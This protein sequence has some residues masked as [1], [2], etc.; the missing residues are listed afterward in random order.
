MADKLG[1]NP[2]KI[3][4]ALRNGEW[5]G[6]IDVSGFEKIKDF[7]EAQNRGDDVYMATL[8]K[9]R[10]FPFFNNIPN[11]F[12]PFH[13]GHSALAEVTDG[14]GLAFADTVGKMPFSATAISMRCFCLSHLLLRP[15]VRPYFVI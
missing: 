1:N 12:L 6:S 7:I 11:W 14:E 4:E 5:G 9:M 2:E 8:G 13:A 10:Q 3:E 15:C